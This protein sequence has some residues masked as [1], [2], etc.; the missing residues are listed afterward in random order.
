MY[1]VSELMT[2]VIP[3]QMDSVSLT[4]LAQISHNLNGVPI[5][6][7][8]ATEQ[9]RNQKSEASPLSST[10]TSHPSELTFQPGEGGESTPDG[11]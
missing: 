9:I 2:L 1:L 8:L 6:G 5:V 4:H 10:S 11:K 3:E 7:E